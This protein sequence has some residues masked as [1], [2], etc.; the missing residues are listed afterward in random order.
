[1][2]GQ[3]YRQFSSENGGKTSNIENW[4]LKH[5]K[6]HGCLNCGRCA[7]TGMP[8]LVYWH[9]VLIKTKIYKEYIFKR[10]NT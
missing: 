8:T 6:E 2:K 3:V 7:I 4:S 5:G 9:E 10:N 1:V